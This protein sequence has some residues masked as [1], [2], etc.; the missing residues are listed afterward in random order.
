MLHS[1][2]ICV[3][4]LSRDYEKAPTDMFNQKTFQK[5]VDTKYGTPGEHN[6]RF[7]S[8]VKPV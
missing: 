3:K 8:F 4:G 6:N 7:G 2:S 1:I 5:Q